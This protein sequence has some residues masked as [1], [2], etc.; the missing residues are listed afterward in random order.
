MT[1]RKVLFWCHLAAGV[2]AGVVILIMSVTGVLLAYEQQIIVVGRY[3]TLHGRATFGGG[4]SAVDGGAHR[5]GVRG[6][7]A[8]GDH[9][10]HRARR[11]R[12]ARVLCGRRRACS[13]V[14]P[15]HG[16]VLGEGSPGRAALL[17]RRDRLASDARDFRRTTRRSAARSPAPATWRSSSSSPAASSLVAANLD[18]PPAAQ[19]SPCSTAACRA[20]PVISTGT[21]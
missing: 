20:R 10:R 2:T 19:Q 21:T 18:A 11:V 13:I 9:H 5:E 6:G 15:V 7:T 12:R 14:D 8:D 4:A 3:P 17:P 1:L 16:T